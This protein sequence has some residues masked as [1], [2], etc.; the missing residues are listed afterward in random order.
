MDDFYA[1]DVSISAASSA[2]S[3]TQGRPSRPDGLT[4]VTSRR[5][6]RSPPR[7]RAPTGRCSRSMA[8]AARTGSC[9]ARW[10]SSAPTPSCSWRATST[11]RS[12]TR[13]RP[14]GWTSASCPRPPSR[15][16]RPCC[17]RAR[18]RPRRA[19]A[20]S[21]GAGRPLH[22]PD[23]RGPRRQHARDRPRG[24]RRVRPRD[25]DRRRGVGRAPA[26]PPRSARE[27]DGRGGPTS[28]SS[29]PTS[30]PAGC[31]R[32]GSSTGRPRAWTQGSWRRPTAST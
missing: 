2:R 19:R 8:R 15:A 18:R 31:S 25:G 5:P 22:E 20:L 24:A 12:S 23:L 26:L 9:C 13:S 14:L 29:R 32:P 21:G 4:P 11:T 27:R 1:S 3:S 16:S 17:R 28:A 7:R 30:S 10:P 6:R